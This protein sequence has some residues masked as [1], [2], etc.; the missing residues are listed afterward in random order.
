MT[1]VQGNISYN[2][3]RFAPFYNSSLTAEPVLSAD[4]LHTRYV[5]Y[6]VTIETTLTDKHLADQGYTDVDSFWDTVRRTLSIQRQR[7]IYQDQGFG[8]ID[9][10]GEVNA[11]G[12]TSDANA[13]PNPTRS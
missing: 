3:I 10:S 12:S 2:G 4:G 11:N 7:F 13:G 1:C 9:V 5:K 8:D 6:T